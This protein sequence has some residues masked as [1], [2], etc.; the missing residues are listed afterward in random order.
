[1]TSSLFIPKFQILGFS[2]AVL[3][4]SF[5]EDSLDLAAH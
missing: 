3:G 1:M 2:I 5:L 4:M